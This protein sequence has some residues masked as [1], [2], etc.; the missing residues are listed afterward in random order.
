VKQSKAAK[1][2]SPP[3]LSPAD[4]PENKILFFI[5]PPGANADSIAPWQARR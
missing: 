1:N 2:I 4:A 3:F 5:Y